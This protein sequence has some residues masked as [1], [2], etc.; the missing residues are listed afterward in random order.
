DC[1]T[2]RGTR[3]AVSAAGPSTASAAPAGAVCTNPRIHDRGTGTFS[4]PTASAVADGEDDVSRLLFGLDVPGRLHHLLER[5]GPIDDSSVRARLDELFEEHDVLLRE[6]RR[7][8]E[9]HPP[10]AEPRREE[11][12]DHVAKMV[13]RDVGPAAPQRCLAPL[14]GKLSN[15]VE[16]H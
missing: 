4:R 5:I 8:R 11:G 13:C 7:Y 14:E 1:P 10:R 6:A 12:E 9:E 15:R 3:I 16:D 2:W